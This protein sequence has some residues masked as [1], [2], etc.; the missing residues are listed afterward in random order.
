VSHSKSSLAVS[1][2]AEPESVRLLR[3]EVLRWL[4]EQRL[5]DDG[6]AASIGLATSEAVANV[7]RHAYAQEHGRVE[8]DAS[9]GEGEVTV[10]VTDRGLGLR[11]RGGARTGL[12][13]PVIGRV[14]NG[15]TVAS[16]DG[17]T[18]VSM[19]FRTAEGNRAPLRQRLGAG[20]QLAGIS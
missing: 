13:L 10:R 15:V 8:L 16:D 6:L 12:G 7:V 17:G 4:R 19:R 2:A 3:T 5:G 1:M 20:R 9:L 14:S 11:T 18:T